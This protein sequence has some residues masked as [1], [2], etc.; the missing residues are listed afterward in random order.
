MAG[1][2]DSAGLPERQPREETRRGNDRLAAAAARHRFE[3]AAR[4][5]FLCECGDPGCDAFVSL[6]LADYER[7]RATADFFTLPG[8]RVER[9]E[10]VRAAADHF[11]FRHAC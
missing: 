5:P 9:A 11:L 8:H 3:R 10:L 4:V 7:A 2:P 1:F 6:T